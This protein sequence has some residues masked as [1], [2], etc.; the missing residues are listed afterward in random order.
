MSIAKENPGTLS[1]AKEEGHE[2]C[3][4]SND[5]KTMQ[6]LASSSSIRSI[7]LGQNQE[8]SASFKRPENTVTRGQMMPSLRHMLARK[9]SRCSRGG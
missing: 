6:V 3:A 1:N 5:E 8:G 4:M 9:M 2:V 7:G